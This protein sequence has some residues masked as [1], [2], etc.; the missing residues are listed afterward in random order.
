MS[1]SAAFLWRFLDDV[2]DLLPREDRQLFETYW[3]AQVQ[4]ASN[5]QQKV[6]EAALSTTVATVPI[7]LTDRWSR[8]AMDESTCDLFDETIS[9]VMTGLLPTSL[10][11]ETV[12]FDTVSISNASRQIRHQ[13]SILFYGTDPHT[14][15]YGKIVA[16]TVSVRSGNIEYTENRDYAVNYVEGTIRAL[17]GTRISTTAAVTVTYD[18]EEYKR[19]LDYEISE[20]NMTVTRLAD[21]QVP[22][23]VEVFASYTYNTTPTLALTG[24]SAVI[25]VTTL[26]D[27]SKDFSNLLS[28]RT[29]TILAG[30]NAG[31]YAI[32]VVVSSTQI[33]IAGTFPTTQA[34]EVKYSI[35]AFP[36]AMRI[37]RQVASIPVLQDR[38]DDPTTV[39]VEGIDHVV[40]AGVLA[41]RT[42]FSLSPLGPQEVRSRAMWAEKV[43]IDA[44]TPYRNFGVLIDFYRKNSESYRLALQ[45]LWYTFWTG[46]TPGNLQRGLHIL[47]GLPY[48]RN[49]GTVTALSATEVQ[50]T[51]PRGQTLSYAI[52]SG[53]EAVVALGDEVA[54]FASLT[55]GVRI[56]DRNNEPGF[57]ASH[58]GLSGIARY[59]TDDADISHGSPEE[60][61]AL[62]LLEHHLFLPQVLTQAL[63]TRVNVAELVTFLNNMKP[64]WTDFVFSFN[65]TAAD[66]MTCS[67]T[68]SADWGIDLT[69]TIGSNEQNQT[70]ARNAYIIARDTGE[71]IGGG[72][73][74]TGN[75]R[76]ASADFA[77]AGIDRNDMVVITEGSFQGYHRVLRRISATVLGLDIPD[78]SIVAT[79]GLSYTVLQEEF[80]LGHDAVQLKREHILL[81]GTDFPAPGSLN[82]G[83]DVDFG[84]LEEADIQALLLV[85]AGNV[86]AEVQAITAADV[87][88][89]EIDVAVSPGTVTRDHEI[90][91]A[92]LTRYDNTMTVTDA[93]A[94]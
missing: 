31:T 69:T 91:S 85:D 81:K 89:G 45:G 86:G 38:I 18:H 62:A 32:N 94:I 15:R 74:V 58:L 55:T 12:F 92:A 60:T 39:M 67:E 82:T 64:Q 29:L 37:G 22:D 24:T 66:E 65:E 33:Q 50:I 19:G 9:L 34:G 23:G 28:G 5:L 42:A 40:S 10:G 7:Y 11:R 3:S 8:F 47:L 41:S 87:D 71:I 44:E 46:S 13:Q 61:R 88:L 52:P 93:F 43:L 83:T 49:A 78:A 21:S 26:T 51:D 90:A 54:R 53:L 4:L 27:D 25:D 57:V 73:Q 77:A 72:T 35:N 36:H 20:V 75:F 63:T 48:V 84:D 80:V 59:L 70:V 30:P 76:D 79:L 2:W 17:S 68:A 56:I 14:L 1:T 16:G 6:L